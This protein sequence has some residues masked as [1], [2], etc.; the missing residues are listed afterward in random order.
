MT[1][2]NDPVRFGTSHSDHQKQQHMIKIGVTEGVVHFM[3]QIPLLV[4]DFCLLLTVCTLQ[5]NPPLLP[6]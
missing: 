1:A 6:H 2:Y 3:S 5:L 4:S